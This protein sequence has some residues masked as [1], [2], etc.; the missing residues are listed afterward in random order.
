[1]LDVLLTV[2][3]EAWPRSVAERNADFGKAMARDFY[4]ETP[5]G[6]FGVPYQLKI[7]EEYGVKADFFVESLSPAAVGQKHL[8]EMVN[9]IQEAKQSVQLHIH[10]EWLEWAPN[11][12]VAGHGRQNMMQF[13]EDQQVALIREALANLN[14]AGAR[15]VCAFRAGNY[16]A[17]ADTL[18]ALRRNG[19]RFDTSYNYPYLGTQCE[20]SM[21][22]P[23]LQPVEL[24]GVVE[25]PI[26][27]FRAWPNQFRH[28]QLTA[29][30][31]SE[32]KSA[33]YHAW[34]NGWK[35]FVIVSHSFELLRG[36][37]RPD[38]IIAPDKIVIRRFRDLCQHLAAHKDKY[39][40]VTF[41]D[42][43]P[44]GDANFIPGKSLLQCNCL[45]TIR[46]YAEQAYRRVVLQ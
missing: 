21:P 27:F 3:T 19:V 31:F 7:L 20:L 16:G 46:R 37:K 38:G 33:L 45:A 24:E 36:R 10:T 35:Y 40:S 28:V 4:G 42:L 13:S 23:L 39:R 1:M 5:K 14:D 43:D 41:T 44:G 6:A 32:M 8:R 9:T 2:D 29:C 25:F 11:P 26:A 15:N 17:N 22:R 12:I 18:R 34:R 30:S